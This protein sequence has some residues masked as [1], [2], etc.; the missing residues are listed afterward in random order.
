MAHAYVLMTNHVH[1]FLTA[2]KKQSIDLTMQSIK[3]LDV[4]VQLTYYYYLSLPILTTGLNNYQGFRAQT[5]RYFC[6]ILH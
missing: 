4:R 5:G 6:L 3:K 2:D 1:M